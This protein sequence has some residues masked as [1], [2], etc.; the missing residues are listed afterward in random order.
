[1]KKAICILLSLLLLLSIFAGCNGN[2]GTSPSPS[3][4]PKPT[5]SQDANSPDDP[6]T[7]PDDPL[8]L[9]EYVPGYKSVD[10][11]GHPDY[12][13]P[14]DVMPSKLPLSDS[15][16]TVTWWATAPNVASGLVELS[17]GFMWKELMKRTNVNIQFFHAPA[18]NVR[19]SFALHIASGDYANIIN[20]VTNYVGGIE[21]AV[22]DE[23]FVNLRD[24]ADY[25]PHYMG[26]L[27]ARPDFKK[28]ACTD[29]GVMGIFCRVIFNDNRTQ[30]NG[31]VYRKDM[32][33]KSGYNN[34]VLPET[35]DEWTD[36]LR[37]FRDEMDMPESII[38]DATGVETFNGALLSG[39]GLTATYVVN[40]GKVEF[41]RISPKY[42]IYL[43]YMNKWYEEKLLYQDFM[44][45]APVGQAA[46]MTSMCCND[47]LFMLNGWSAFS[48]K[49]Y[50]N[51]GVAQNPDFFIAAIKDPVLNKGELPL[52]R[53]YSTESLQLYTSSGTAVST[54]E[55]N[56]EL[57]LRLV[58]YFYSSEGILLANYG[59][60][61]GDNATTPDATFYYGPDGRPLITDMLSKNET[62]AMDAAFTLYA[63]HMSPFAMYMR[64][65]DTF[66]E[67]MLETRNVWAQVSKDP[68][69]TVMPRNYSTTAEEGAIVSTVL[70]D[71]NTYVSEMTV[72]FIIGMESLDKWDEYVAEIESLGIG[73]ALEQQQNAIDRYFAR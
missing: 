70:A 20:E 2:T 13:I 73:R 23:V 1:M 34:G 54:T 50:F 26:I 28:D 69:I 47:E 25:V 44:S 41:C 53:N 58:D 60:T 56:R 27:N 72:K 10:V 6:E 9:L 30:G 11:L 35:F 49:F 14:G 39:L 36:M 71:V 64:E 68:T 62:L 66:N 24:W 63:A 3:A 5:P 7:N 51:T 12:A 42:K 38:I 15:G 67:D 46:A 29:N 37:Y 4:T 31:M 33:E 40:D 21:K 43:E 61:Q 18:T 17:D 52:S 19:E 48:G 8:A 65:F 22:D 57:A 59:A 45:K 32:W 55:K 16:E